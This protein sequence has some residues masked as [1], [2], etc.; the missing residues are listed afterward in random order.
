MLEHAD[1]TRV[2]EAIGALGALLVGELPK[3]RAVLESRLRRIEQF[4]EDHDTREGAAD[5]RRKVSGRGA[6]PQLD[7]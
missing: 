5:L 3:R 4:A 2:R 1:E 7:R 6:R